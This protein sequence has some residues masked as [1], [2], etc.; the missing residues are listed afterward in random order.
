MIV[1]KAHTKGI[2]DVKF[3][4]CGEFLATS[5]NDK[6]V[7][8]WSIGS[9]EK[10]HEFKGS[11]YWASLAWSPDGQLLAKAGWSVTVWRMNDPTNPVLVDSY[12]SYGVCFSPDSMILAR[13]GDKGTQLWSNVAGEVKLPDLWKSTTSTNPTGELAFSPDGSRLATIY[14]MRTPNHRVDRWGILSCDMATGELKASYTTPY[15][16]THFHK[17]HF[18]RDGKQ[19]AKPSA[20]FAAGSEILSHGHRG[21]RSRI[22]PARLEQDAGLR[23]RNQQADHRLVT[24][25]QDVGA[26]L[27]RDPSRHKAAPTRKR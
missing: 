2:L 9:Q 24:S 4:P 18:R 6:L 20:R 8:V 16:I 1:F 5:S 17:V 13:H 22:R 7:R 19:I 25:M 14:K 11:D 15:S 27:P 26:G 3:S 10:L 23:A 12:H 21:D